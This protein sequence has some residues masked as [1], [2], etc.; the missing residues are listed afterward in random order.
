MNCTFWGTALGDELNVWPVTLYTSMQH[1]HLLFHL[2][3][4]YGCEIGWGCATMCWG[5]HV[6]HTPGDYCDTVV[7]RKF[8]DKL[9][10]FRFLGSTLQ[11]YI[12]K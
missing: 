9:Q 11:G 1:A 6:K 2:T 4:V 3:G 10:G 12:A 8:R 5:I 7:A